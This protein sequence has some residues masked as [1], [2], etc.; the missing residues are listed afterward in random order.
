M[1]WSPTSLSLSFGTASTSAAE[2]STLRLLPP[3]KPPGDGGTGAGT[4]TELALSLDVDG[5]IAFSAGAAA[6]LCVPLPVAADPPPADGT[7][8]PVLEA[9][10]LHRAKAHPAGSRT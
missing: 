10:W 3:T 2:R 4:P 5:P 8:L 9:D 6:V 7:D 1:T